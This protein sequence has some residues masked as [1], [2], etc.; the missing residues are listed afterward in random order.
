MKVNRG[1]AV[2]RQDL[3]EGIENVLLGVCTKLN[4]VGWWKHLA[5]MN[6]LKLPCQMQWRSSVQA[7]WRA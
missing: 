3:C 6:C 1:I 4:L 7:L 5:A 2:G